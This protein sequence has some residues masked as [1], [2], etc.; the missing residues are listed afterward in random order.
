[1]ARV[2]QRATSA[3]LATKLILRKLDVQFTQNAKRLPGT[4]DFANTKERWAIFVN[5]C[6]WHAHTNCAKATI[7]KSNQQFWKRKFKENRLRDARKIRELQFMG[8]SV[9]SIWECELAQAEALSI[10]IQHFLSEH[11]RVQFERFSFSNNKEY[12]Q[13]IVTIAGS[14]ATTTEYKLQ[15]H[16]ATGDPASAFDQALLRLNAFT[17]PERNS[18]SPSIR[19]AD[20]FSGCGGLSLGVRE[21]C[22]AAGVNFEALFAADMNVAGLKVYEDNFSPKHSYSK[23][24]KTL[25]N[26][27]LGAAPTIEEE[28]LRRM[29]PE[30]D[31]LLAGPPCQ[32]YSD[33]N[34]HTRR[35]DDRNNLYDRVGRFVEI[36]NPRHILIENVPGVIHGHEHSVAKT[37]LTLRNLGYQVSESTVDL[38]VIGV[39]QKRKR[40]ILIAST[41]TALD[42]PSIVGKYSVIRPRSVSWAISDLER[43]VPP[44]LLNT[45]SVLSAANKRRIDYLQ[46][47]NLQDLPNSERP[48]CHQNDDHSYKS[49]Y[50]RLRYSQPAQTITSGFSSPGQ[51]RYIHPSKA[52]TL[53][54]HEAARIQF[55]PDFFNFTSA[56]KRGELNQMIGNAVP[57]KLSYIFALEFIAATLSSIST[58]AAASKRESIAIPA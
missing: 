43:G 7:P 5:G 17:A 35:E 28:S 46:K 45:P 10:R 3:E 54:P 41:L 21:A 51:G 52:R 19:V 24:I 57:M 38:S 42:I 8:Y 37:A 49:M 4:P 15:K 39:P 16:S 25:L 9:L 56:S 31:I 22:V 27:R 14:T 36:V 29:L 18:F 47:H 53:T 11:Q 44:T 26:G 40:H 32:G 55:F 6:F 50:G 13:R 33:L 20:L 1:M 30:I 34:N 12:V 48:E 58:A 23:D 2:R